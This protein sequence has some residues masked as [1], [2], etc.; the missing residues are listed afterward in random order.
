MI[1][2]IKVGEKSNNSS[3]EFVGLSADTKPDDS[4][5]QNGSLFLEMD[6]KKIFIWDRENK[7][8]REL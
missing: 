6:T 1:S 2:L 5:I 4:T 8:W 3:K 7:T